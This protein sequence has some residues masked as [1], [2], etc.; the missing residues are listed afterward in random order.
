MKDIYRLALRG[1]SGVKAAA[2][3]SAIDALSDSPGNWTDILFL[4]DMTNDP[5][6]LIRRHAVAALGS[7]G[8]TDEIGFLR[9][10]Q[11]DPD[12]GVDIAAE[13]ALQ[14]MMYRTQ[15]RR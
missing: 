3:E 1:D 5:D 9:M 10:C 12:P 2:I 4:R 15:S 14:E 7:V 6:P 8:T 13:R 11:G